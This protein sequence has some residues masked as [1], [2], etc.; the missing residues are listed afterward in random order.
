[1]LLQVVNFRNVQANEKEVKKRAEVGMEANA[2]DHRIGHYISVHAQ[3]ALTEPQKT[4]LLTNFCVGP[5][6]YV[7]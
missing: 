3:S 5:T 7:M 1:M 2:S 4:Q 6:C